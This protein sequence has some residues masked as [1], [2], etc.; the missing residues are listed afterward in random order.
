MLLK[1]LLPVINEKFFKLAIQEGGVTRIIDINLKDLNSYE[2]YYDYTVSIIE[3]VYGKVSSDTI[4]K[5]KD[6]RYYYLQEKSL[7]N[8]KPSLVVLINR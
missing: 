3:L 4:G 2:R 8:N 1:E 6:D 7:L 5:E